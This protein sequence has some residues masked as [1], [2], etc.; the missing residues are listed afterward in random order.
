MKQSVPRWLSTDD[1]II[2]AYVALM[3][4]VCPCVLLLHS[5]GGAFGFKV[6]EQR[7]DKVKALIAIEPAGLGDPAKTDVLKNIPTLI[8][9]GD[10]IEKDSRWPKIRA[11]G[12][13][14]ADAIRA[15]GGSVDVVDLPQAGIKGN[16]HMVMMDKNNA[17][18]AALIQKWLEGK[19]LTK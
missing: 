9:Y 19:G 17:E 12:L 16:S 2:A 3:D 4:K 10:Y 11:N 5:Q 6:A 8:V 18:V 15:A 7:P 1:A 14:F 13:A